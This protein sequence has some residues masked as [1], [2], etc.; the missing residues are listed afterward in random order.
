MAVLREALSDVVRH[1]GA[2]RVDITVTAAGGELRVEVGDD[3]IGPGP[4][5]RHGGL[6]LDNLA[7]RAETLGGGMSLAPGPGGAGTLLSWWAPLD[8]LPT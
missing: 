6:G 3:G 5:R 1:A 7:H 8:A 4:A 2:H